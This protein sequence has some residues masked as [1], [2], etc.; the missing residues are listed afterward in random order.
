MTG[1]QATKEDARLLK[2]EPECAEHGYLSY[3]YSQVP[4]ARGNADPAFGAAQRALDL[5]GKF[6]D[7]DP[8]ALGLHTQ[9]LALVA[10]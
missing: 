4:L 8:E 6:E 7:R 5:G 2:D 10:D 9:V 3:S 1:E